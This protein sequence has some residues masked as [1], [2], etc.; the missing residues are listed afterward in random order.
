ML[1]APSIK[2]PGTKEVALALAAR[3]QPGDAVYHYGEYFHDFSFYAKRVVGTVAFKGELGV[4][5]DPAAQ[6][7]GRFIDG[8]EFHRQWVQPGRIYA[9]ARKKD[10]VELFADPKFKFHVIAES[11]AHT[12]FSN[13]P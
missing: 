7:S 12:L 11:R 3:V 13:Q 1:A 8:P 6:V 9:V 5:I 2:R 10:V 4:Q